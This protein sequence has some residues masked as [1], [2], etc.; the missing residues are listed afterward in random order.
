VTLDLGQNSQANRLG[1]L[2]NSLKNRL[3]SLVDK[4]I[5][6]GPFESDF[7]G[8]LLGT[9]P[10]P[11]FLRIFAWHQALSVDSLA[12]FALHLALQTDFSWEFCI[13]SGS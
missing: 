3:G 7:L 4:K 13:A 2:Q 11:F 1:A 10:R 8:I 9:R 5:G 6:P 12:I